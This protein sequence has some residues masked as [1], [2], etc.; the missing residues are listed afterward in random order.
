MGLPIHS[1]S[2]E[3]FSLVTVLCFVGVAVVDGGERVGNDRME[4]D[5]CYIDEY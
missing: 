3:D 1:V 5:D 4:Q 2:V